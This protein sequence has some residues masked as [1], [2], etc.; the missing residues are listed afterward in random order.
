VRDIQL[1]LLLLASQLARQG[2]KQQALPAHLTEG[3]MEAV[4]LHM[5]TMMNSTPMVLG[6]YPTSGAVVAPAR[7]LVGLVVETRVTPSTDTL[8][9]VGPTTFFC[10]P[11]VFTPLSL[12]RMPV[13]HCLPG[14][15]R[16]E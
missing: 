7:P 11:A 12:T 10:R 16:S 14:S 1:L 9:A 6:A 13:L 2:L 3:V 4:R 5:V 8:P 15:D